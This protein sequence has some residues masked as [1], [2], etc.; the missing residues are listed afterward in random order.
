MSEPQ[1]TNQWPEDLIGKWANDDLAHR[2]DLNRFIPGQVKLATSMRAIRR[3]L[4]RWLLTNAS[5]AGEG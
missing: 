1:P 4:Y 3:D 5:A 2:A